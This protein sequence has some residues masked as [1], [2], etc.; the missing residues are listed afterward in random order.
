MKK[1]QVVGAVVYLIIPDDVY[2]VDLLRLGN[3]KV[4]ANIPPLP[5]QA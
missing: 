3:G 2:Q 5:L 4:G 1:G